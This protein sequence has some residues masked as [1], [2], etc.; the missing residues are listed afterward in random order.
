[1]IARMPRSYCS[2]HRTAVVLALA[3]AFIQVAH[4]DTEPAAEAPTESPIEGPIEAR[5]ADAR[6]GFGWAGL[7]LLNYNTDNGVGYGARLVLYDYGNNQKPY[8]YQLTLQ[9]FQ[10][11]GGIMVHRLI[12]DA[13]R[14]R[15]SRWRIDSDI[16]LD[17]DK[18]SPYYGLGGQSEYTPAYHT[19]DDRD[20]LAMNPDICPGNP[21]FRGLR[22]YQYRAL[23]PS[24]LL[25]L[26][27]DLGGPWQLMTGYRAQL[28]FIDTQYPDDLGQTTPSRLVED[29]Q[30]GEPIVGLEDLD[31]G[32]QAAMTRTAYVQAGLVYDTRDNE[33]APTR[34]FWHEASLRGASPALGGQFWYWGANLQLRAYRGL[35]RAGRFV[36]AG[37]FLLDVLG[38]DVP[39]YRLSHTGGLRDQESVGGETSVRGVLRSRFIGK[40][41]TM[42][43]TELRWRWLTR[44][45][46]G[47]RLDIATVVGFDAGRA[48]RELESDGPFFDLALGAAAG[49]RIAWDENFMVRVDYGYA[50]TEETSGLYINFNHIF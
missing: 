23:M 29:L 47:H 31:A 45:P 44:R 27:R 22:Y 13:P 21:D 48:W 49:L 43:S 3:A 24:L 26:R 32:G 20:A 34:G 11:T 7:P 19:C 4:A 30:A 1:M 41:K 2:V 39:F 15:G 12:F 5:D 46:R 50:L 8:R 10:T 18:F 28:T 35:D 6:H 36:L 9:F 42:L 33:P 25:N 37:R 17:G 16:R 38:G 40:I 14:F